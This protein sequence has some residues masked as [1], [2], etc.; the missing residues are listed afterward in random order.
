MCAYGGNTEDLALYNHM[1]VFDPHLGKSGEVI[2]N[3]PIR[4]NAK[5]VYSK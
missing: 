2:A 1:Q 3:I 4:I 5:S